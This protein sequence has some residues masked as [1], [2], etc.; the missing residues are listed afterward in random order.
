MCDEYETE[1]AT[2]VVTNK[3][4]APERATPPPSLPEKRESTRTI[5]AHALPTKHKVGE[6]RK[7]LQVDIKGLIIV[8]ARLLL[9][10]DLRLGK[11]HSSL[12]LSVKDPAEVQLLRMGR[13]SLCTTVYDWGRHCVPPPTKYTYGL[14]C[15]D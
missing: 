15:L 12:V 7:W 6:V 1:A 5:V 11:A 4:K 2:Q 9:A 13:K 14:K 8:G 3:G 10:N